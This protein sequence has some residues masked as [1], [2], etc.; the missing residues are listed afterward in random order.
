MCTG[1]YAGHQAVSGGQLGFDSGWFRWTGT[2]RHDAADAVKFGNS[3]AYIA[4][5]Y[6]DAD[7]YIR[8]YWSSA[9]TITLDVTDQG[10]SDTGTWDATGA[11]VAG[12][13]YLMEV[14]YYPWGA[15]FRVDSV[16]RITV[17]DDSV[18]FGTKPTAWYLA[19]RQ[20]GASIGD[21][22]ISAP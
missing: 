6:G 18:G 21:M 16:D 12:T 11:I 7:D 9:N 10:D 17:T 1:V 15:V 8:V 13:D 4:E 3:N 22:V 20:T 19:G 14:Q 2:P 5:F